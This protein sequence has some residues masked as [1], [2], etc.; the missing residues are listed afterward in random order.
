MGD[1]EQTD[2]IEFLA[3]EAIR[4]GT[5]VPASPSSAGV[6]P[7]C[8]QNEHMAAFRWSEQAVACVQDEHAGSAFCIESSKA[9]RV[10]TAAAAPMSPRRLLVCLAVL[11]WPERELARRTGYP[12]TMV[13]H[14]VGR[15]S[16]VPAEVVGARN[17]RR[18]CSREAQAAGLT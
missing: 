5:Q 17:H 7:A 3:G 15:K 6:E 2:L 4:A 16:P 14:R 1:P 18:S 12:Q 8:V 10:P 9:D 13:R 11:G